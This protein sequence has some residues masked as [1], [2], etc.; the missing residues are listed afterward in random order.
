VSTIAGSPGATVA[1]RPRTRVSTRPPARVR[2][3]LYAVFFACWAGL[4]A[5]G[6]HY[7]RLGL[8][9]RLRSP[10]HAQLRPSGELGLLYAYI[11]TAVLL[12]LLLYS[13]RKRVRALH[14]LGKLG[15]WLNVHIFFGIA[16]PMMITL[17][18]GFHVTGAI[19][20]GYWAMIGV[21]LSG[22]VGYYLLRK[23][24]GALSQTEDAAQILTE[25]L[26]A[27]DRELT[28]RFA[29]TPTDL[30]SLRFRA[31]VDRAEGM[32]ALASLFYLLGR[33]FLAILDT[34]GLLP[35]P[36][37]EARLRPFDRRLLRALTRRHLAIERK[38]AFLRQT[39]SLFHYWH[40][41]HKPF[42]IVLFLMMGVHIGVAIWLGYALP[43]P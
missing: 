40:T 5:Y 7:Y 20:V 36:R 43:R 14:G 21:M 25:E 37:A 27:L 31:G 32:G 29:F 41:I 34:L 2:Y 11:G 24:G 10:G 26:E 4:F 18:A 35:A 38:R 42:T 13:V 15:R 33:D 16:G 9:E 28:E 30:E 19:A 22:F 1:V 6:F 3:T 23:V 17:H 12:L 8:A 39:S